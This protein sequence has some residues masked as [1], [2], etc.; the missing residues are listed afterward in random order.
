MTTSTAQTDPRCHT[1]R[2]TLSYPRAADTKQTKYSG[3]TKVDHGGKAAQ[4]AM[5]PKVHV[6]PFASNNNKG[7]NNN[8]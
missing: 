7:L 5:L 3:E 6:H 8:L 1:L 4:R 2:N